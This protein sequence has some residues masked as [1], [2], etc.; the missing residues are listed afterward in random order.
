M[1]GSRT[2]FYVVAALNIGGGYKGTNGILL[3]ERIAPQ[4]T[5][6]ENGMII[7]Y[8]ADRNPGDPF[9]TTPRWRCQVPAGHQ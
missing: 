6:T 4:S 3:G 8:Y 2:F 9:T 5:T 7:V 1:G